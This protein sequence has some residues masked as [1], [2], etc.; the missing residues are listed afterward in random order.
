MNKR[1]IVYSFA[2]CLSLPS[3][4]MAQSADSSKE[5]NDKDS[6]INIAYGKQKKTTLTAAISSATAEDIENASVTNAG[7]AL[8]GKLSGLYVKQS[9][10]LVDADVP[11]LFIR[12][13][14]TNTGSTKV[15][16]L[17]DGIERSLDQ[18]MLDDIESISVLKDAAALSLYG[19]RGANGVVLVTTK[20]GTNSKLKVGADFDYGLQMPQCMPDIINSAEYASFMNQAAINDG[21]TTPYTN[22]QIQMFKNGN[23]PLYPD[24]NWFD[25]IYKGSSSIYNFRAH[26]S[27]GNEIAQYYVSLG[28][29]RNEGL[30]RNTNLND[31][32]STQLYS[33]RLTFKS[34]V[35]INI[36]KDFRLSLDIGGTLDDI[37]SPGTTDSDILNAAYSNGPH[38]FPMLNPNGTLGGNSTNINNPYGLLNYS[39]Y[40]E[41]HKRNLQVSSRFSYDLNKIT[42]GLSVYGNIAFDNYMLL[43]TSKTKSFAVYS[44]SGNEENPT[45]T[46]Y[47]EESS[48][49]D[50]SSVSQFSRWYIE[51]GL[52]YKRS[53]GKHGIEALALYQM[54]SYD[55]DETHPYKHQG[56]AGRL[57]YDYNNKYVAELGWSVSASQNSSPNN[58]WNFFPSIS[59]AWVISNEE[60]MKP[61]K[62]ID[63][64]KVRAS[65]G[66]TGND[67]SSYGRFL[68]Y[69]YYEGGGAYWFG[70]SNTIAGGSQIAQELNDDIRCETNFMYNFGVDAQIWKKLD[71]SV[72]LFYNRRSNILTELSYSKPLYLGLAQGYFNYGIVDN[73]GIDFNLTW[74]DKISD[75]GYS[76]NVNG[77]F[78]RSKV[79]KIGE[80][81][82]ADEYRSRV[83]KSVKQIF[84]YEAIGFV[85]ADDVKNGYKQFGYVLKEG[86]VKYKDMNGDGVI[87]EDDESP[88]SGTNF[89]EITL[90]MNIGLTYKGFNIDTQWD[91]L[92][93]YYV[94]ISNLTGPMNVQNQFREIVENSWSPG[95]NDA[96]YPRLTTI[97][98][99]NNYKSNTLWTKNA[100][101]VRLRMLE[102]GYTVPNKILDRMKISNLKFFLRGMNVLNI[103]KFKITNPE[104]MKSYPMLSSYHIGF[105]FEI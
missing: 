76:I 47:G 38:L 66:L 84:G 95:N 32:F 58:R 102:L 81:S 88:I 93:N 15:L 105:K 18:V 64:L 104:L 48:L 63:L 80:L 92:F 69:S 51:G 54:G 4:V 94:N 9:S 101:S 78:A 60:F 83:G 21:L 16:V 31:D 96:M 73:K 40:K 53:Y 12:G 17:V 100:S 98:N 28:Y 56:F 13:I 103:S 35:D 42:E 19:V 57:N 1:I 49:T 59:G 43:T 41:K 61:F 68:F 7:N 24:V 20:R 79:I 37:N 3:I 52:N 36:N 74:K 8:Y 82:Y 25:N 46:K 5:K 86:D 77:G 34:N 55:N 97:N 87:N 33:G 39:G 2:V 70:E 27:G 23:N 11:N 89:P 45:Y 75:L 72:D 91:G 14:G 10:G 65:L 30:Y 62:N 85:T 22:E 90:G 50:G 99:M 6:E 44:I 67:N 29:M 71:L 26:A